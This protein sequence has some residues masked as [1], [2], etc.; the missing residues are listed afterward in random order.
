MEINKDLE[1]FNPTVAELT[2]MV[3]KTKGL[4]ATDLTDKKQLEVVHKSRMELRDARVKIE[5]AGK[6]LREDANAYQKAVI[7]KEK[8]LIGIIEPEEDRLQA[9][10][11]EA[12]DNAALAERRAKLPA[13]KERIKEA[14]LEFFHNRTDEEV[15]ELDANGFEAYMNELAAT[16]VQYDSDCLKKEREEAEEKARIEKAEADKKQTEENARI[17]AEQDKRQAELDAKELVLQNEKDAR[18]REEKARQ[19]ERDRIES[20][21]RIK[22]QKRLEDERRAGEEK[23]AAEKREAEEKAR[24][25]QTD[26]YRS[27]RA[28]HGWTENGKA[29]FKEENTGG[30]IILWKKMGSF[31]LK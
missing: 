2:A 13:R 28:E 4:T 19:A 9:I 30:E 26:K 1:K 23:A 21:G 7:A 8:E 25:E 17:K 15:N 16:K 31:K 6:S 14:K 20:E 11:Q 10:E 3:E 5:K 22:E 24:R 12:I 18:E 29:D 27:F